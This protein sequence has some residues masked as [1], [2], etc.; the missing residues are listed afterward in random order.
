[1]SYVRS[2]GRVGLLQTLV[3]ADTRRFRHVTNNELTSKC[4]L[5]NGHCTGH[6]TRTGPDPEENQDLL[7]FNTKA[8]MRNRPTGEVG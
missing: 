3:G 7:R 8:G 2:G 1:M 5:C 6:G 4:Y